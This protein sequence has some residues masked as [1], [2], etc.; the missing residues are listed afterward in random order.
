MILPFQK[1]EFYKAYGLRDQLPPSKGAELVFAGRSNVGKSSLINKL[2][3]RKAL[4]RVSST[5]GKTATINF[6]T[7]C[8]EV[9]LV[10]LPGYGYAKRSDDEKRRWASLMEHYFN[11]GRDIRLVVLLL[12]SRHKPSAD[13]FNMLDFLRQAELPFMVVLTKTDKL[14]KTEYRENM[15]KFEEWLGPYPVLRT[16][17]F[18]VNGMQSAEQLRE[19]LEK[20]T[21]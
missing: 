9:S 17:P 10:D 21:R 7:L 16:M 6:F 12:D 19:L 18:T 20:L 5:P 3:G 15:A 14:N 13:D 11:S 4:A 1:A 8:A 2:C